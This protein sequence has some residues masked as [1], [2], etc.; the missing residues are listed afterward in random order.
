MNSI[1]KITA[2]PQ[3]KILLKL[4]KLITYLHGFGTFFSSDLFLDLKQTL[5]L[6]VNLSTIRLKT[7][8]Q[9]TID[10]LISS[11]LAIFTEVILCIF[12]FCSATSIFLISLFDHKHKMKRDYSD[13]CYY[14]FHWM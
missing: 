2:V 1:S 3:S 11:S 13:S 7:E 10:V 5:A 12:H 9:D 8:R 14:S 6:F 4:F